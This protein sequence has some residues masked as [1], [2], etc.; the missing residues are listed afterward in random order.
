MEEI[1]VSSQSCR[2]DCEWQGGK[3]LRLLSG[4][5]P[6]IRPLVK[7]TS[8]SVD[9]HTVHR[10][11]YSA[12]IVQHIYTR[13]YSTVQNSPHNFSS[14]NLYYKPVFIRCIWLIIIYCSMLEKHCPE[15]VFVNVQGAQ[16]S[17]PPA[18]M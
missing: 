7:K 4:F 13:T 15:P 2:G 6:R 11:G 8:K 17:I 1:E 10:T 16:E 9:L 5:R 14:Y 12:N 18:Y 3:L